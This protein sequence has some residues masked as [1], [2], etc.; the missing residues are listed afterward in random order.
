MAVLCHCWGQRRFSSCRFTDC[1][2]P[3]A[4]SANATPHDSQVSGGS[5]SH[6]V[7]EIS[8]SAVMESLLLHISRSCCQSFQR[9]LCRSV[10][11]LRGL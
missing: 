4:G 2:R 3:G 9:T 11:G 6:A 5:Q 8:I 7:C 10:D 1:L